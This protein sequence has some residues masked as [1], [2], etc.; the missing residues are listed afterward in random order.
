MT[1]LNSQQPAGYSPASQALEQAYVYFSEGAGKD[2]AGSRSVIFVTTG[3]TD[4]NSNL[5]CSINTCVPNLDQSCP[6]GDAGVNCCA[7]AGYLCSDHNAVTAEITKLA[8]VGIKTY[9]VGMPAGYNELQILNTFATAGQATNATGTQGELFY[10][11]GEG[12]SGPAT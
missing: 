10:W 8:L 9:V 1:T 2:L 4:C 5:S 7:N 12:R 11:V 3:G 6:Q